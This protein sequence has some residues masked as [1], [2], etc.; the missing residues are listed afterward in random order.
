M[1]EYEATHKL[2][3]LTIGM[4]IQEEDLRV[5][6][7]GSPTYDRFFFDRFLDYDDYKRSLNDRIDRRLE[8]LRASTPSAPA[9]SAAGYTPPVEAA[10]GDAPPSTTSR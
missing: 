7:P 8:S 10:R 3:Q 9:T 1:D 6:E 4:Q 5:V 2:L